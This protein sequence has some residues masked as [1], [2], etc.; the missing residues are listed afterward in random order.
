MT[1]HWA[2]EETD[3]PVYAD[4]RIF[5]KVPVKHTGVFYSRAGR[6]GVKSACVATSSQPSSLIR[7]QPVSV[8]LSRER[9]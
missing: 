7:W 4:T 9:G 2:E 6:T 8:Q 5:L 1:E 3:N